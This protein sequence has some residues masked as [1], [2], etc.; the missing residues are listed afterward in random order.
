MNDRPSFSRAALRTSRTAL[1]AL[2][3][4]AV[5]STRHAGAQT[6]DTLVVGTYAYGSVDRV[7]AV[8]PLAEHLGARLGR[9]TR[10]V[11]APDPVALAQLVRRGLV[12]VV[13]TNTFGYLLLADGAQPA[14][15]PVATFRIPPGVRTNY[16]A[17]IVSRDTG[18]R[19]VETLAAR[20][21]SHRMALVAPG[22]TTGNLVPRL[23]LAG[24]GMPELEGRLRSVT[25]GGTHAATFALLD[26]G[27][28]D[29]AALATEEYERQVATYGANA[30]SRFAVLWRSPDIQLGPV[31]VR[32]T[33][34]IAARDSIARAVIGLERDAPA[35]FAALRG[36][37]VE[38]AK[39]DALV[40]AHDG[41][42]D[43][44]RRLFGSGNTIT[45]LIARFGR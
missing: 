18:L 19:S 29:V 12:D 27:E 21:A 5:G 45:A 36:G 20:A 42:Y 3:L 43:E 39:S 32:T 10:V 24:R 9:P 33:L 40:A 44:V 11:A 4:L 38:A 7:G 13:V 25:Y 2:A 41:T 22:S 37:W 17:V 15:V 14:A 30:A 26:S 31:A 28:V 6:A 1:I 8:T 16:G 34:P 35:A 23:Y